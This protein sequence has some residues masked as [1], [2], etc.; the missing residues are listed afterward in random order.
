[1][2][3]IDLVPEFW[4]EYQRSGQVVS[5]KR[6]MIERFARWLDDKGRTKPLKEYTTPIQATTVV[7]KQPEDN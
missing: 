4:G 3:N 1:M 5:S 6:A 2:A 7:H